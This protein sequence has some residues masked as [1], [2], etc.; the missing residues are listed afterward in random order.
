MSFEITIN[1]MTW[2]CVLY[3][4]FECFVIEIVKVLHV[5]FK[6][7][8]CFRRC[9]FP[10][11]RNKV[12][13]L[14]FGSEVPFEVFETISICRK[15]ESDINCFFESFLTIW[16]EGKCI[17][18][19]NLSRNDLIENFTELCEK[20]VLVIVVFNVRDTEC[21]WKQLPLSVRCRC[22]EQDPLVFGLN[23]CSV[24]SEEGLAKCKTPRWCI[25]TQKKAMKLAFIR[26]LAFD[27][28]P[29]INNKKLLTV[30]GQFCIR[31][32]MGSVDNVES[33][34]A[35]LS[36]IHVDIE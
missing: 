5:F 34:L 20:P 19:V 33:Q 12:F 21:K 8:R 23:R 10:E 28:A 24:E 15:G 3:E 2:F 26:P 25:I 14:V 30:F 17:W 4:P 7:L 32:L 6:F 9:S 18:R 1:S 16:K 11:K 29:K 35:Q 27:E 13:V 36:R 31:F 22:R